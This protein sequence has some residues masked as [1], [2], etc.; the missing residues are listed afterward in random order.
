MLIYWIKKVSWIVFA[1]F[2]IA[3]AVNLFL[4]PHYI[5]AG[6]LT[7]L[8]IIIEEWLN[9]SRSTVIM[10]GNGILLVVTL[11]FLGREVFLNT[12]IGASIL[13]FAISVVP[14]YT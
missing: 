4:G 1:I 5:A 6:G 10:A 14:R 9:I 11:I 12:V 13:P 7:G 3:I 8:A 2:L